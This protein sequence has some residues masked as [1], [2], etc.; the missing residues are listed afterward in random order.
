MSRDYSSVEHLAKTLLL[1]RW[2]GSV[3]VFMAA[4]EVSSAYFDESRVDGS[5]PFPVVAGFWSP[6]ELWVI[7]ERR[8]RT[9]LK[10]KPKAMKA[11]AYVRAHP[12]RFAKIIKTFALVPFYATLEHS[13]F[14]STFHRGR[15]RSTPWFSNA[16]TVCASACFIMLNEVAHKGTGIN[17]PIKV[18]C[19]DGAPNKVHFERTYRAFIGSGKANRLSATPNF[20]TEEEALP[21]LAADLYTWL[22][23]RVL[24]HEK[25]KGKEVQA[26][27]IIESA[28]APHCVELTKQQIEK[29]NPTFLGRG[30]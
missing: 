25:L 27:K 21:L 22:V 11:K 6:V 13:Y 5:S 2:R 23:S 24:N 7:C 4:P 18:V 26:L 30:A 19:D 28:C 29:D 20:A 17:A 12:V 1:S 10:K 14:E 3:W 16:Y 8:F 9:Q 15:D